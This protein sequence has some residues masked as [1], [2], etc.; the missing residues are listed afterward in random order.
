[1]R[2]MGRNGRR[3]ALR[4]GRM[5]H[6]PMAGGRRFDNTFRRSAGMKTGSGECGA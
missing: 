1:M 2:P 3:A 4:V 6:E 5:E